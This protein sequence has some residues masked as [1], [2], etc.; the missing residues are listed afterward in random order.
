MPLPTFII[1]GAGL[2]G[3]KAAET[4]RAEGFDGRLV[5]VGSEPERP[6]ERPPLSK[7]YL[8]G[9]VE[10][11][12]VYV[13]DQDFYADHDIELRTSTPVMGLDPAVREVALADGER[14]RFDRLLLTLG[15]EPRRLSVPGAS[16]DGVFYLRD[17]ADADSLRP[18][19]RA[20]ARM[21]VVGGGWIGAEVAASAR[22]AGVDVTIVHRRSLPLEGVLGAEVAQVFAEVHREHGVRLIANAAPERLEG[23][24]SVQR[25]VLADGR[26]LKCDLAM[27]GIGAVPRT[28]LAATAGLAVGDGVLV[29][30]RLE[31]TAA[32]IFAAGDL[33]NAWH[34]FYDRRVRVEHWANALNQGPVAAR[35]MLDQAVPYERLP[36]FYSDQYEL[37]MEYTGL[38]AQAN[39]VVLRG[40]SGARE[41]LAFWMREGRVVAGMSLNVWAVTEP[42]Q[43]LIRSRAPVDA[44]T[45]AD[46]DVPLEDLAGAVAAGSRGGRLP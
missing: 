18:R 31:T 13:H 16:L 22:Q 33:A 27:V 8:R 39:Q 5:L 1:A 26:S 14:L 35:N 29:D 17:L 3:A 42:I 38:A 36:Y 11:R 12:A 37:G 4:L 24:G 9:E 28:E 40:D 15:S 30:E 10:R 20:G 6:Y 2:A 34:P 25:V 23:V 19:L 46:T 44:R 45:L 32:G 41:L 7:G 43:A 21:V